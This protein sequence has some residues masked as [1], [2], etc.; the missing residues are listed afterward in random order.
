MR[1]VNEYV[2]LLKKATITQIRSQ[3]KSD[4]AGYK[5]LMKDLLI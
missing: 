3:F 2:E 1:K 5:A 4:P